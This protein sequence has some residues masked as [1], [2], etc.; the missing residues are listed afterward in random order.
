[1]PLIRA[2][3]AGNAAAA[4]AK[5]GAAQA[6]DDYDRLLAEGEI[7]AIMATNVPTAMK[8]NPD[9]VRLFPNYHEVERDY[10]KRTGI[11]PIMHL[12]ALRREVHEKHPLVATSLYEALV[13]SRQR[14]LALMKGTG[15][16]R[17]MLPWMTDQ[18]DEI[19]RIGVEV[20]LERRTLRDLA[21]V[22]T[23][24]LG[25]NL[26]HS[27]VDFLPRRCH[28]T[29]LGRCPLLRSRRCY[30]LREALAQT[31][32]DPVLDSLRRE[33]DRVG[34]CAARGV[35]VCDH[36]DAAE[37]EEVGAAVGVRVE[38]LVEGQ[39]RREQGVG[40]R[41]VLGAG[42]ERLQEGFDDR[43]QAAF[44]GLEHDVAGEPVAKGNV[45]HAGED[46]PALDVPVEAQ[47]G[48]GAEQRVRL[49]AEL[50]ALLVLLA[51]RRE[52]EDRHLRPRAQAPRDLDA[53]AVGQK[54]VGHAEFGIETRQSRP[55]LGQLARQMLAYGRP[56]PLDEIVAKVDAVTVESARAAGRM[57]ISRSRPAIAALGPGSGLESTAAI[58]ER[59][60][61]RAA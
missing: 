43:R 18:L 9:I 10:F 38:G 58:A 60:V 53:V 55:R 7:D 56:I 52:H 51:D 2:S 5:Y 3:P 41:R 1:M 14:A 28:L 4:A 54:K 26:F 50:V 16:L 25:Q 31:L 42:V 22:H 21:V 32:D 37:P 59:L 23:E 11:F 44:E 27:F 13:K 40:G 19:E 35:A 48:R 57:L 36:G 61:P 6:F 17:Y 30:T 49:E 12:V 15:A 8:R 24:L 20:L 39:E 34:D 33:P 47:I 45:R 46:V 29:S